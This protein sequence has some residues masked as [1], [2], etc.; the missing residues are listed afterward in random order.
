MRNLFRGL[1]NLA[2]IAVSSFA[3]YV[4]A[5]EVPTGQLPRIAEPTQVSLELK[6]DPAAQRFSGNTQIDVTIAKSTSLLW[7]HGHDLTIDSAQITPKEGKPATA[8]ITQVDVSGVLKVTTDS[9]LPAG[10][11][12][13]DIAFSAPFGS[14]QGAY[15]VK[16]NGVEYVITQMEPLGARNTFPGFDEPSFKIPWEVSLIVP[17]AMTAVANTQQTELKPAE[18]GW[19]RYRYARSENLPSYLLAF[20]VGPWDVVEWEDIPANEIRKT[21]LS[22]RGIAAKGRGNEMTYALKN[23]AQMVAAQERYFGIAYPFD[24][25]DL[26]AAPDFWAGAM[27]NAGLIVYRDSLMFANDNSPT[28]LRQ[29]YWGTHS[30]EL[31]HQWFGNYVTMPWWDDLW[32]NEGFATWFGNKIA[33]QLKPEF[34][35]ERSR[36]E[37]ALN[38]MS[39]DSLSTTRRIHEPVKDFT[40]IQSA[41]D[42]ITYSKGGAVLAMFEGY[43][44]ETAFRDGLRRYMAKHAR[45]N[46]KSSDLI[47]ALSGDGNG[48]SDGKLLTAAFSS[49]IDQ[50]GVPYIKADLVCKN[51]KAAVS[52]T[53]QRYLPIGSAA[54]AQQRWGVPMCLRYGFADGKKSG[55]NEKHCVLFDAAQTT[56]TLPTKQCPSWLMP[57]A[58]GSGYY[59]FSLQGEYQTALTAAFSKLNENEQRHFA[60]SLSASF[61]AG[62]LSVDQYLAALPLLANASA[63]QTVTAPFGNLSWMIEYLATDDA[64]RNSMR[65]SFANAYRARA[66]TLGITP[67]PSDSDDDKLLRAA[68]HEFMAVLAE[69][70][71]TRMQFAELG[72][73]A[74]GVDNKSILQLDLISPDLRN[75]AFQMAAANGDAAL[76]SLIENHLRASS[77]AILRGQ[78]LTALGSFKDPELAQKARVIS[79]DRELLRRN[80]LTIII[81]TQISEKTNRPA[82]LAWMEQNLQWLLDQLSPSGARLVGIFAAGKCSITDAKTIDARYKSTLARIEGGP[83]ALAQTVEGVE[84]CS[85]LRQAHSDKKSASL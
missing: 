69:D 62:T 42:G 12:T 35:V 64:E 46:A 60:D 19:K 22:L 14:L 29:G 27:E 45:G 49:F 47:A 9:P 73:K 6:I 85:A 23:T 40:D 7:L 61:N 8:K 55:S 63:R 57:N 32:L 56:I 50:P 44:G 18:K 15:K 80:E 41:F 68:L 54:S 81:G 1:T 4:V 84:L 72:K 24:K 78:L 59:R 43:L 58:D 74:L 13:I 52:L 39:S 66:Q 17:E 3:V 37:G 34:N 31:A 67:K 82:G 53:Q 2:L 70:K 79:R 48:D 65:E 28:R 36:M 16:D 33:G 30:H 25:L 83:R 11:A 26:L 10:A 77:D 71:A 76:F 51:G 20:A 38:A 75:L 5:Q 21:P